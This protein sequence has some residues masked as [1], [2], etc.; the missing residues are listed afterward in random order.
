V[1]GPVGPA[2]PG[3]VTSRPD[4]EAGIVTGV[5]RGVD[6]GVLFRGVEVGVGAGVVDGTGLGDTAV[7]PPTGA[8]ESPPCP[9]AGRSTST[10]AATA[11]TATPTDQ[12]PG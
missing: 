6:L 3:T 10:R 1:P 7:V 11:S 12:R 2:V 5:G 9:T 8:A 4:A